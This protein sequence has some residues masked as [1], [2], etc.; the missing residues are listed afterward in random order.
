MISLPPHLQAQLEEMSMGERVAVFLMQ[1]G[2]DVTAQIFSH[3]D[4]EMVTEISKNIALAKTIDKQIAMAIMEEF[5]AIIQ[6]NQYIS[7]GGLEY[8]KELLYKALGPEEARKVLEK[9]QKSISAGKN[10]SYLDKI[11]PQQLSDF[12][13]NEHP[14]TIAL[15]LAHM[16]PTMAAETLQLFPD[17][18]RGEVAMRMANLGDISPSIIKKVSTLLENKLEALTSY[19]VEVGGPR[20]VADIFNRL[21]SKAAK[22]TIAYI[23]QIDENLANSIKEMMFTFEDIIKLDNNGVRE[24]LKTIDKKALTLA[25]KSA[26]EPLKEK[27]FSNMSQRAAETLK[28]ELTFLGAVKVK[29]VEVAQRQVVEAVQKLAEQGVLELGEAEET[30]E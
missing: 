17:E 26:S 21:G 30:I 15:I 8:A 3:L 12:I 16:D 29:E 6:S 19:K 11:K 2:D 27:I 9:L 28:E 14:Q 20:A 25:L 10:F 18:T 13:Q 7:A 1:L 22:A 23:E 24:I 5:Y 4:I